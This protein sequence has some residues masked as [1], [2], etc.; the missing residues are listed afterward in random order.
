MSITSTLWDVPSASEPKVNAAKMTVSE[1]VN[2][3]W[4]ISTIKS[5]LL[6]FLI[7]PDLTKGFILNFSFILS[8]TNS[9]LSVSESVTSTSISLF[10]FYSGAVVGVNRPLA[11]AL[12]GCPPPT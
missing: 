6:I 7:S 1:V 2:K 12:A 8:S 11:G 10:L 9:S 4:S 5:L 3:D